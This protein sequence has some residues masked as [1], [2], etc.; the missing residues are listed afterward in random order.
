MGTQASGLAKV[1]ADVLF[2][3]R[4]HGQGDLVPQQSRC[5]TKALGKTLG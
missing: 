2:L 3:A 5:S 1:L 4:P